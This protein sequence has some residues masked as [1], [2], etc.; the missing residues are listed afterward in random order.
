MSLVFA[1]E[2]IPAPQGSK[3]RTRYGMFESSKRVKPWRDRVMAA[4]SAEGDRVGLLGPLTAPYRVDVWFFFRKPRTTSL[5][6]PTG[7]QVGDGDKLTRATWDAL[8]QSGVITDDR[9]ITRWSGGKKWA[10]PGETP[11]AVIR[12]TELGGAPDDDEWET[13]A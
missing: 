4:A 11:G 13:D 2:G 8:T 12:I 9:H 5:L 6:A 1:V 10:G 3:T 7:P